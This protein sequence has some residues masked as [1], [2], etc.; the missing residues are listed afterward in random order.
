MA[1]VTIELS[2][3]SAEFVDAKVRSGEFRDREAVVA[4][5]L[6]ALN[7]RIAAFNAEVQIGLDAYEAGDFTEVD[8]IAAWLT[9]LR[10]S[11]A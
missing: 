8:D 11:A 6:I 4:A 5:A 10:Q 7:D 9:G 2:D 3:Q 1:R